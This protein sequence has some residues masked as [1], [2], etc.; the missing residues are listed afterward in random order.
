M[1]KQRQDE[2]R[3]SAKRSIVKEGSTISMSFDQTKDNSGK[4][5]DLAK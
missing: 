3:S 1:S 5:L 2:K 4:P